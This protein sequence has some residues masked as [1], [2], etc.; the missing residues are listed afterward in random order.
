MP[1]VSPDD[2]GHLA[3]RQQP[4]DRVQPEGYGY[5]LGATRRG[6][7]SADVNLVGGRTVGKRSAAWTVP[8]GSTLR[9]QQLLAQLGYLPVDFND[10]AARSVAGSR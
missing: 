9:L 6:R 7:A 1:P 2:P 5:G 4:H 8:A 10:P 3:Q